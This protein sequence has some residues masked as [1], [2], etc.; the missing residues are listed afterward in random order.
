MMKLKS[1]TGTV[2]AVPTWKAPMRQSSFSGD[3]KSDSNSSS[4]LVNNRSSAL[5]SEMDVDGGD[6]TMV[7]GMDS[8][9]APPLAA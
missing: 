7:N 2:W 5:A 3:V 6:T 1:F 9:P 8:S 4:D